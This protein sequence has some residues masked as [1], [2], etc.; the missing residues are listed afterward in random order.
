[1]R[2][3]IFALSIIIL[4]ILLILF[5]IE[6]IT[7]SG[8]LEGISTFYQTISP[9]GK[10]FYEQNDINYSFEIIKIIIFI[11][12]NLLLFVP[13]FL[14]YKDI[15]NK[16][17]ILIITN[18]VGLIIEF[19]LY[20]SYLYMFMI[21]ILCILYA[22]NIFIQFV[23]TIKDKINLLVIILTSFILVLNIY[24][25]FSHFMQRSLWEM[26][27][28][29]DKLINE[30]ILYSRI[31]IICMALWVVPYAILLVKEIYIFKS[32]TK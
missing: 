22:I 7:A 30:M 29:G 21:S 12:G 15:K 10:Y 27:D 18:T 2:K 31:N 13:N 5:S 14:L 23:D 17:I 1:M 3:K 28:M 26:W 16:S 4:S 32:N 9:F 8:V 24:Y 6:A 11:I 25:L 19:I 20:Q